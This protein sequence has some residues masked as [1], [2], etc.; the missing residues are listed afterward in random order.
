MSGCSVNIRRAAAFIHSGKGDVGILLEREM[1][2]KSFRHY[3]DTIWEYDRE[4]NRI[5]VHYDKIAS[6]FENKWY[7]EGELAAL[8]RANYMFEVDDDV[9]ERYLNRGYLRRLLSENKTDAQFHLRFRLKNSELK[10]YEMR[11]DRIDDNSLLITGRDIYEAI[12]QKSAY[13]TVVGLFDGVINIDVETKKYIVSYADR[14]GTLPTEE[15]DYEQ[16]LDRFVGGHVVGENKA[17]VRSRMRLENVIK[18]LEK[19]DE[20]IVYV[21]VKNPDGSVSYKRERFA[22]YS[23]QKNIITL[24]RLDVSA[25]VQKYEQR[26][27][28][29]KR[30]I[31]RDAL[32]GAKNRNYYEANIKSQRLSAGVA[33]IDIDDFKLFNDTKGH[34]AGDAALVAIAGIITDI[35][36]ERDTLIRYGGDEFL[37]LTDDTDE[38]RFDAVLRR[39]REDVYKACLKGFD[40]MKMSVS[41][42]GVIASD[43]PADDAVWRADR[44]MYRAKKFKNT[45]VTGNTFIGGHSARGEHAGERPHILIVDDSAI[46][47]KILSDALGDGFEISEAA[48]GKECM[49]ILKDQTQDISLILLDVIMPGMDGFDVLSEMAKSRL[50]EQIPVIMI[51]SD[52]TDQNISLAY[53]MGACDYISRPFDGKIVNRRVA[54]TINL[55]SRQRRFVSVIKEQLQKKQKYTGLLLKIYNR[56]LGL[57]G[58]ESVPSVSNISM[59]TSLLLERVM[60]KKDRHG[61]TWEDRP[62]IAAAASVHDI[63][64]AYI[65]SNIL[66]KPGK[67]TREEY[68]TVKE[69]TVLGEKIIK[70]MAE[71]DDE[72]M[73]QTAAMICRMH[74][75]RIDGK[76]YPDGLEGDSIP[77][78]V[79]VVSLADVYDALV[80]K[81]AYKPAYTPEKALEMIAGGECG[82]FDPVLVECLN[83]CCGK[84]RDIYDGK[85]VWE[86]IYG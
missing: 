76:G 74:H 81:R 33:V 37:L 6:D 22:Y 12:K 64:K 48:D 2:I 14:M 43:E 38:E 61:L 32:T 72:P 7:V 44:F 79:Q 63:G 73:L 35:I 5:F 28:G 50:A 26:I 20:Y 77:I 59:V 36:S 67:L 80:S 10:W 58:G 65:D 9:M 1:M 66:C 70:E 54:N 29:F 23:D 46:N 55:Y 15:Y 56:A 34:S 30:E 71:Y 19:N 57:R 45:V 41:I 21:S 51:S 85:S 69:H 18:E 24:S 42:G 11:V 3:C 25:I 4:N 49:E 27:S 53:S 68:E 83:E 47:R 31:Y 78:A 60:C 52:D 82:A 17:D 40:D 16:A 86:D 39:I 75:E 84:L 8:F 62:A 13:A